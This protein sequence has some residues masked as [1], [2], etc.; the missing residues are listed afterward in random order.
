M[1]PEQKLLFEM[2]TVS[3]EDQV[4]RDLYN[5][6]S[7][8]INDVDLD[9]PERYLNNTKIHKLLYFAVEKYNLPVTYSWYLAG[10]HI[11]TESV[12]IEEFG[13]SYRSIDTNFSRGSF[14]DNR[15]GSNLEPE[16]AD[17]RRFYKGII[18]DVWYTPLNEFLRDFYKKNAPK[19]YRPLYLKSLDLRELLNEALD[20]VKNANQPHQQSSLAQFASNASQ[21]I[22]DFSGQYRDI[23][24]DIKLELATDPEL[25][26]TTRAFNKFQRCTEPVI[27]EISKT[28]IDQIEKRHSRVLQN[29]NRLYFRHAWQY[30]CLYISKNTATGPQKKSLIKEVQ[31]RIIDFESHYDQQLDQYMNE[32]R[33]F[34]F[35]SVNDFESGQ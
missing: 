35:P 12:N 2:V 34:N 30:P 27:E 24:E 25:Q 9:D 26:K 31:Q 11:A 20:E 21:S 22:S 18:E 13:E 8:A 6:L 4:V 3:V 5:G 28:P 16:I 33:D 7:L 14:I 15:T 10:A 1:L 17:Y 23:A 32:C 29:T 19:D